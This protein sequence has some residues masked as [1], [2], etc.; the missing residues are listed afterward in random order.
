MKKVSKKISFVIVFIFAISLIFTSIF[1]TDIDEEVNITST[2]ASQNEKS[3]LEYITDVIFKNGSYKFSEDKRDIYL[4]FIRSSNERIVVDK[5]VNKSGVIISSGAIDINK[6]MT[7]MHILFSNDTVR[8]NSNMEY[9]AIFAKDVIIDTE[10]KKSIAIFSTN[11]TI[12]DK[13]VIDEDLIAYCTNLDIQGTV[14]GSILGSIENT[15]ISGT[16]EKDFRSL[17]NNID[18]IDSG[19]IIGN[20]YVKTYNDELNILEKYPN[21]KVIL[22]TKNKSIDYV[23]INLIKGG[24]VNSLVFG[25]LYILINRI[26]NKKLFVNVLTK[27]LEYKSYTLIWGVF[28]ILLIVPVVLILLILSFTGLGIITM[29]ILMI[30]SVIL[31]ICITLS[32]FILG[33]TIYT[34][35]KNNKLNKIN[36]FF[37]EL[38]ILFVIYLLIYIL[39]KIPYVGGYVTMAVVICSVGIVFTNITKKI[40]SDSTYVFEETSEESK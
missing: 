34:Y 28:N 33:S 8:I 12:T 17:S 6:N 2:S 29:P 7:G 30:Y 36:T 16:I 3:D 25:L 14:K 15:T 38:L 4:P 19:N 21:A 23:I 37:Y 40:R 35:L 39:C 26:T 5:D 11:I 18:I 10:I 27:V 13:G 9:S 22:E 1:A 24:I 20:I 31:I 32:T